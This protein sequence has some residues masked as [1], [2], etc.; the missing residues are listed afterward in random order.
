[1]I[2]AISPNISNCEHTLNTLRYAYRVK[3]IRKD[4]HGAAVDAGEDGLRASMG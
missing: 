2:A 1:M 4:E 3:E